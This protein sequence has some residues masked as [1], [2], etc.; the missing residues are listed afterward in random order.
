MLPNP[1]VF[2]FENQ[3][4]VFSPQLLL[5]QEVTKGNKK[6]YILQVDRGAKQRKANFFSSLAKFSRIY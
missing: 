5:T 4:V 6:T 3:I 1:F 2:L